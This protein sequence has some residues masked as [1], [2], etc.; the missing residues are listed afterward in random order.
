MKKSMNSRFFSNIRIDK[1]RKTTIKYSSKH[2]KR[3]RRIIKKRRIIVKT[4]TANI[5]E[6]LESIDKQ[7]EEKEDK[8]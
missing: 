3:K 5:F 7:N 1:R 8:N 2:S 4:R 6:V